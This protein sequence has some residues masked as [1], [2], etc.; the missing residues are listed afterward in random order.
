[1]QINWH[2]L[3]LQTNKMTQITHHTTDSR[4][5]GIIQN[6]SVNLGHMSASS[7]HR[8]AYEKGFPKFSHGR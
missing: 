4:L 8:L 5:D 7:D 3:L 6:F 1:M 2:F